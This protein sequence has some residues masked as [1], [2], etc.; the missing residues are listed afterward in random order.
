[1]LKLAFGAML[2]GTLQFITGS[3]LLSA[4]ALVVAGI[5]FQVMYARGLCAFL[6]GAD[7][8]Q[9]YGVRSLKELKTVVAVPGSIQLA[10][11]IAKS[12]AWAVLAVAIIWIQSPP[13]LPREEEENLRSFAQ[14]VHEDR[15]AKRAFN[16]ALASGSGVITIPKETV[17]ALLQRYELALELSKRT[18]SE[19]LERVHPELGQIVRK[20]FEKQLELYTESLRTDSSM[21]SLEAQRHE[22]AFADWWDTHRKEMPILKRVMKEIDP[23]SNR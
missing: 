14:A 20:H 9:K 15:L 5:F 21:A 10:D 11:L 18:K 22:S 19:V 23:E 8:V 3:A 7:P 6:G 13:T 2:G 12:C 1:L 16:E 4:G 17:D